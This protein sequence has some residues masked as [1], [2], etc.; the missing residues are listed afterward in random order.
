MD[1]P[2]FFKYKHGPK[3]IEELSFNDKLSDQLAILKIGTHLIITGP[4]GSGKRTRA[5]VMINNMYNNDGKVFKIKYKEQEIEETSFVYGES[6]YHIELTPTSFGV[7]DKN[8]M[9]NF[10]SEKIADFKYATNQHHIVLIN[11]ANK[12]SNMAYQA[13]RTVLEKKVGNARFIFLATGLT[14]IPEPILS[15]CMILKCPSPKKA[16]TERMIT[17]I[18]K[19][20]GIKITPLVI[21]KII[22]NATILQNKIDL[23]NLFFVLQ[24]SFPSF[25]KYVN[26]KIPC[27]SSLEKFMTFILTKPANIDKKFITELRECIYEIIL[28]NISITIVYYYVLEQLSTNPPHLNLNMNRVINIIAKSESQMKAG[29]KEPI[30]LEAL[31]F[32]LI[33]EINYPT[34]ATTTTTTT[35]ITHN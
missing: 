14:G 20:E 26:F 9:V 3:T 21:S 22:N 24:M 12:V 18:M 30:H 28:A 23:N 1:D 4:P 15:R 6:Y 19:K 10:V 8:M 17:D 16:D 31:V 32:N 25:T 2:N 34:N 29:N 27:I 33:R 35:T 7:D 11:N 13:L 5:L